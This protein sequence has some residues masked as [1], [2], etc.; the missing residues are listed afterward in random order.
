MRCTNKM[1]EFV[2]ESH[3]LKQK[4]KTKWKI[5]IDFLCEN[6]VDRYST[7]EFKWNRNWMIFFFQIKRNKCKF[8]AF[9]TLFCVFVF[10]RYLLCLLFFS[11]FKFK[12]FKNALRFLLCARCSCSTYKLN[13][14][15]D[16]VIFRFSFIIVK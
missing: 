7:T 5:C 13:L 14:E 16:I 10:S 6:R 2:F 1:Y 15:F 11:Q 3:H 4:I 12:T 9:H 8:I